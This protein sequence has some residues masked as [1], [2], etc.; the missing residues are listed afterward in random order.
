MVQVRR[1]QI[2]QPCQAAAFPPAVVQE[3]VEAVI[4]HVAPYD[5]SED[6]ESCRLF[7]AH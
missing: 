1:P 2:A 4:R 3:I 7:L 6:W 5:A